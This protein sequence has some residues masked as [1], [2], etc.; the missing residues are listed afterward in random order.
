MY[1]TSSVITDPHGSSYSRTTIYELT[2]LKTYS[3]GG[4]MPNFKVIPFWENVKLNKQ[5]NK[6]DERIDF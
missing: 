4:F 6:K 2:S 1:N 5:T 3:R